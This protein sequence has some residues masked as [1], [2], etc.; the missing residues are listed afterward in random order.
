M[1][2]EMEILIITAVSVASLHTLT[3]PDH[4]LPFIALSRSKFW[5]PVKTIGWTVICGSGHVLSSVLIGLGGAALGWSL[6]KISWLENICGGIAGWVMLT[7]GFFY[8][9]WGL[10]SAIKNRP[11]KHFDLGD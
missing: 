3:G 9:M 7:F 6:S 10:F 8:A 1:R 2:P 4:Y 11:H 5:S